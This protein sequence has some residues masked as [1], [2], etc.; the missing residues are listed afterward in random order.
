[1][2]SSI[3]LDYTELSLSSPVNGK[4]VSTHW[5]SVR[6]AREIRQMKPTTEPSAW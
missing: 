3:L 6:L 4:T 2:S 5:V 1:M